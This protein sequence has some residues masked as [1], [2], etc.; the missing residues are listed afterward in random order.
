MILVLYPGD[1]LEGVDTIVNLSRLTSVPGMHFA[2]VKARM[3]M[4]S[5]T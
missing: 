4:T 1:T 2:S 5:G 3:T